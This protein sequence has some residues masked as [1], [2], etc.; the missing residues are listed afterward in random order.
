MA[1]SGPRSVARLANFLL[2]VAALGLASCGQTRG[3]GPQKSAAAGSGGGSGAGGVSGRGGGAQTGGADGPDPGGIRYEPRGAPIYTRAQRLT[4]SQFEHAAI[5]I[6]R[7]PAATDL[8]SGLVPPIAGY[9]QF[10]N[11]EHMLTMDEKSVLAFEEAAE[12]AAAL[13]TESPDSLA[14]LY[15][16]TDAAGLVRELG[17]RAFRRPL[18]DEEVER[19]TGIF[20]RGEELYGAGFANGASLVIRA[21]LASP[22]FLYRTELGPAGEPLS[23][24]EI[25]AKV[26][27]WLL[28]TNPSDE[29]LEVAAS[30][31][32]ND[33]E[34]LRATAAAM[35]QKPAASA[36]MRNFHGELYALDRF[37]DLSK[38]Q[39]PDFHEGVVREAKE[40]AVRFF[41]RIFQQDSKVRDIFTSSRGFV[42]PQLAPLYAQ[43]VP[44]EL[45]ERELGPARI[46]YF[47]QVPHLMV[48]SQSTEPD[49]VQRAVALARQALCAELPVPAIEFPPLPPMRPDQTNRQRVAEYTRVCGAACHEGYL[50]PLGFAFEGFDAMGVVRETDHGNPIDT[51]G[52]FPFTAGESAFA[53]ARELMMKLAEDDQVYACYGQMLAGHGLQRDLVPADMPLIQALGATGREGTTK[54]I[55]LALVQEPAFRSRGEDLP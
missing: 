20:A 8:K 50:D 26:S 23:G 16:G 41:E 34:S 31:K 5:D 25:A 49:I 42:G 46:G 19:Y 13:A 3:S 15:A 14:R 1:V 2:G 6:L 10:T 24:Y 45:E 4:I 48:T 7:L 43:A 29:L 55:A 22:S 18:S 32:L 11:N 54:D 37:D 35:L 9:T 28:D 44:V 33:A 17:R 30:G 51:S 21:M 39:R 53:D 52:R 47:M 38:P 27:L 12:K 40:A 36:V